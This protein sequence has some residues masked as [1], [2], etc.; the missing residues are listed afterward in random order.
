[1]FESKKPH[2][3]AVGQEQPSKSRVPVGKRT[4]SKPELRIYGLLRDIT[5]GSTGGVNESGGNGIGWHWEV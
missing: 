3:N 2:E 1:M 5:L 4:Y